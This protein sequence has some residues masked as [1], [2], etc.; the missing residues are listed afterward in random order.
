MLNNSMLG[1]V[2]GREEHARKSQNNPKNPRKIPEIN[3][4]KFKNTRDELEVLGR[5]MGNMVV[6]D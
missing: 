4:Q 3:I 2:T 6:L 5:H 1:D